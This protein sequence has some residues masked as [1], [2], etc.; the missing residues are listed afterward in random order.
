MTTITAHDLAVR[1]FGSATTTF[2]R[3]LLRAA[4]AIDAYVVAR[5]EHRGD[6][7]RRSALAAQNRLTGLRQDAEA[8]AAVGILPR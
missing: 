3:A 4:S 1:G 6:A 5:Q 2:E 7:G 8:R